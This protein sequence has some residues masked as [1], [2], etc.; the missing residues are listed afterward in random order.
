MRKSVIYL[1]TLSAFVLALTA[2]PNSRPLIGGILTSVDRSCAMNR[3]TRLP[4]RSSWVHLWCSS[5]SWSSALG[6]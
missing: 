5:V 6:R 3:A 4:H 2:A 1:A